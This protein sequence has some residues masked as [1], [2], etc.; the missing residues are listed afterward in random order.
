MSNLKGNKRKVFKKQVQE[1][2]VTPPTPEQL[3]Q[4]PVVEV[5]QTIQTS[6]PVQKEQTFEQI[7]KEQV[8]EPQQPFKPVR[9][10]Y[11]GEYIFTKEDYIQHKSLNLHKSCYRD[12][13][14]SGEYLPDMGQCSSCKIDIATTF[15]VEEEVRP[16]YDL[17]RNVKECERI[18][19][20]QC[21]KTCATCGSII[22]SPYQVFI[23][24]KFYHPSC[25]VQCCKCGKYVPL[26]SVE[27]VNGKPVCKECR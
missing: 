17:G 16:R 15:L 22:E 1:Q 26:E 6:E 24:G 7:Q 2:S 23:D 4:E 12:G 10:N 21:S 9:C 25:L 13:F 11:C 3:T 14:M 5:E 8:S 27:V 18:V 20:P 19:C